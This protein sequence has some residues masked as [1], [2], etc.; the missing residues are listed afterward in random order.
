MNGIYETKF[1][2]EPDSMEIQTYAEEHHRKCI[3]P[4]LSNTLHPI[5]ELRQTRG[6]SNSSSKLQIG[7]TRCV[8]RPTK[9]YLW[10]K[11]GKRNLTK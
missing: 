11:N 6:P 5:K 7:T 2:V 8:K 9:F 4:P 3:L 10:N 1:S